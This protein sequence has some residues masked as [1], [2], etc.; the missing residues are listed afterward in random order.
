MQLL[1]NGHLFHSVVLADPAGVPYKVIPDD[2]FTDDNGAYRRIRVDVGQTGFFAG[3]EFRAF[4][5]VSLSAGASRIYKL[6]CAV[7]MILGMFTLAMTVGELRVEAVSG[8]TEG[9]SFSTPMAVFPANGMPT[10]SGYITQTTFAYGG[11]HTG[12]T[13]R[14][15]IDALAGSNANNSTTTIIE[16]D[17]PV[18]RAAI[19]LYLR[20]SNPSNGVST[21]ILKLRWE[22][23]P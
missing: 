8:G 10:T 2:L 16:S 12:G 18:G 6:N 5:E 7:P 3:R 17:S 19:P 14:D 20:V 21:G 23:R 9:G 13:I 1:I 11:T 4:S 22:E 15:L